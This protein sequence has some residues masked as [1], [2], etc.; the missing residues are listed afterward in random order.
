MRFTRAFIPFITLSILCLTGSGC[1]YT[2]EIARTK[3]DIERESNADFKTGV[4]VSMG[5]ELFQT[6]GWLA[7]YV[8]DDDAQKAS[9]LAYG[10]RRIKA[11]IYPVEDE[12]NFE[13]LDI[14]ELS[15]FKHKGWKPALKVI[16]SDGIGWLLYRE[17]HGRVHD[18][19]VVA[20]TDEE[21]VLARIR[22]N[23]DELLNLA[24]IEIEE[25]EFQ[26]FDSDFEDWFDH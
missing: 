3:H 21:L 23:L 20:L 24:L 25:D 9:R 7:N 15:R 13:D 10:I 2:N 19:F 12:A 6:V 16:E 4:V 11:G 26:A 5:P 1:I 17:R 8:D 18:L 14:P 22:G